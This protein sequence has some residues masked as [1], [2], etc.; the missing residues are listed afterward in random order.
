MSSRYLSK[1]PPL[2]QNFPVRFHK[3]F[4]PETSK[5]SPSLFWLKPEK[6]GRLGNSVVD[7]N[8]FVGFL[9]NAN[10][11]SQRHF[12]EIVDRISWYMYARKTN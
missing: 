11:H 6:Q 1:Q 9:V 10:K 3:F 4:H 8:F 5:S 7:L 12:L 2:K